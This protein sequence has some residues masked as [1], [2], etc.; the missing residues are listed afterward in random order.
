MGDGDIEVLFYD[1][2]DS[3]P[4]CLC[5]RT[6]IVHR[7]LK[8]ENILVKSN[9]NQPGE[10]MMVNIKVSKFRV[11]AQ[12]FPLCSAPNAESSRRLF[13]RFEREGLQGRNRDTCLLC[14][15]SINLDLVIWEHQLV[16]VI[17]NSQTRPLQAHCCL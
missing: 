1:P 2:E 13:V 6:D 14:L 12:P 11:C 16:V 5:L 10:G 4:R 9:E 3:N 15:F 7:D 8:L 17:R